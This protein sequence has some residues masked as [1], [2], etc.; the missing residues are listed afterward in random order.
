[1]TDAAELAS[2]LPFSRLTDDQLRR[3]A[4]TAADIALA[5]G[6]LF[7]NEGDP[8][9]GCWI[10]RSGRVVLETLVPGRGVLVV[11][12][13]AAGDLL[14]ASWLLPPHVW[15]FA[16][17]ATSPAEAIQFDTV[18]LRALADADPALGYPLALGF[19]EVAVARLQSTRAR[20]LD[21]YR[22]PREC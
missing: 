1:M 18:R 22:S 12:T 5:P 14:G 19:L 2:F 17:V 11:Q 3:V 16:A 9:S 21:L 8:A 20:L 4:G 7:C 13:L 6:A 10:I 15:N